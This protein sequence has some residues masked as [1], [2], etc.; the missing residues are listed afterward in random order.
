MLKLNSFSVPQSKDK[1]SSDSSG[2]YF[3]L[4]QD[5]QNLPSTWEISV[6]KQ[7]RSGELAGLKHQTGISVLTGG[8]PG[9]YVASRSEKEIKMF[10]SW[11][12]QASDQPQL[13]LVSSVQMFNL[14]FDKLFVKAAVY[15]TFING[16]E[17]V[18]F[19]VVGAEH[20]IYAVSGKVLWVD[21]ERDKTE[22][23]TQGQLLHASREDRKK[24]YLNLKIKGDGSPAVVLWVVLHY[25]TD[26]KR[27]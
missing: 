18:Q 16:D 23:L 10:E 8:G 3:K 15:P 25:L 2:L 9:R 5:R 22:W 19:P 14:S 21:R 24:E 26:H 12:W 17:E 7:E 13:Y 11:K 6:S 1:W 20:F 4:T 27:S